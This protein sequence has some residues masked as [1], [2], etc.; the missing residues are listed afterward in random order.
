MIKRIVIVSGR[1]LHIIRVNSSALSA[2]FVKC[3][4][5]LNKI[6]VK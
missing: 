1:S 3:K 4:R 5:H 2:W 6:K